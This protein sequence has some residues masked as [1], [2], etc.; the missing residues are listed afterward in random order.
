MS[1]RT[2][3][4][5]NYD[6]PAPLAPYPAHATPLDG[7]DVGQLLASMRD[8]YLHLSDASA[9]GDNAS[10][11]GHMAAGVKLCMDDLEASCR[12][13]QDRRTVA[14]WA[15]SLGRDDDDP[16]VDLRACC[17]HPPHEPNRCLET[18]YGSTEGCDCDGDSPTVWSRG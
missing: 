1:S 8:R 12:S 7:W 13:S 17:D 16:G 4:W 5:R 18:R 9:W 11:A 10:L 14:E 2:H 3:T 15:D 6:G